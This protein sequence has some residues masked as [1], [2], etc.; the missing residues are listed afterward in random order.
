VVPRGKA[1]YFQSGADERWREAKA[2]VAQEQ[3]LP[4]GS[5]KKSAKKPKKLV[6]RDG[7]ALGSQLRR[8]Q[9][10]DQVKNVSVLMGNMLE[11]S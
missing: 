10:V 1:D 2:T 8:E 6:E 11:G 5:Q 7:M 4:S 9:W 3:E